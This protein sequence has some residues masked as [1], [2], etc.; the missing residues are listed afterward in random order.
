M[1]IFNIFRR[2]SWTCWTVFLTRGDNNI[3]RCSLFNSCQHYWPHAADLNSAQQLSN[4][5]AFGLESST[6]RSKALPLN[7]DFCAKLLCKIVFC[8]KAN[9]NTC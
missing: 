5:V 8:P 3:A 4:A 2:M 1:L 7:V 6:D 9:F